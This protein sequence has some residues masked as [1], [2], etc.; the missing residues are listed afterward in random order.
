[1]KIFTLLQNLLENLTGQTSRNLTFKSLKPKAQSLKLNDQ[2]VMP[3]AHLVTPTQSVTLNAQRLTPNTA[4]HS[5]ESIPQMN[6]SVQHPMAPVNDENISVE[7]KIL[8]VQKKITSVQNIKPVFMQ[9]FFA[10]VKKI[11]SLSDH[12]TTLLENLNEGYHPGC[13]YGTAGNE[14]N[15]RTNQLHD[16]ANNAASFALIPIAITPTAMNQSE[17][18]PKKTIT[19]R[20]GMFGIIMLMSSLFFVCY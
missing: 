8:P 5:S 7:Y 1:M 13:H 3:N 17:K 18:K 10:I 19:G 12:P 11:F 14:N 16:V 2:R 9:N 20:S 15:S 4:V 6:E